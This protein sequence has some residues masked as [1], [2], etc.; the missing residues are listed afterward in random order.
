MGGMNQTGSRPIRRKLIVGLGNPG[1]QYRNTRHNIGFMVLDCIA[2][3]LGVAF[4]R[5]KFEGLYTESRHEGVPVSLLKPL[6][7]MNRSGRSVAQAA[8]NAI[9]EPGNILVVVDDVHLPLGTLR[10]RGQGSAGG[11]NGLK[12]IIQQLGT[13]AF[14][15]LRIGIGRR[16]ADGELTDHVLG[17]FAPDEKSTIE[18]ALDRATEAALTFVAAGIERAMNA[19]NISPKQA[20]PT[21]PDSNRE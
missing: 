7:F 17:R 6:T 14:P 1:S 10:L 21:K 19:H 8:R 16:D 18:E 15:R 5:E 11:H 9:P 20:G 12:S 13:Q 4:T 3:R 2:D